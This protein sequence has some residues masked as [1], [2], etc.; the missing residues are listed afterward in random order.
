MKKVGEIKSLYRYPVKSFQGE[1]LDWS[2]VETYGLR[3]DRSHAFINHDRFDRHLSAKKIPYLLGY[4]AEFVEN[5]Q[6]NH[7]P[8]IQ[9]KSPQGEVYNWGNE[10]LQH[11]TNRFGLNLSMET[12]P[13]NHVDKTAVDEAH[14]LIT[15]DASLSALEKLKGEAVD[16]RRFRP[17][18][19][20]H[21]DQEQPFAEENWLGRSLQIG[22]IKVEILKQCKRCVMIGVDPENTNMDMSLLKD[23]A[24]QLD[25]NFGVYAKVLQTGSV[26][27]SD[28]VLID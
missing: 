16:M 5:V 23:V 20:L 12:Y 14:L 22:N 8:S 25:A 19:V 15:T 6:T 18:I 21:L 3:G 13:M 10:F 17:N 4:G 26:K 9:V 1:Q 2:Q 7:F 28:M 24:W 11:M 27:T